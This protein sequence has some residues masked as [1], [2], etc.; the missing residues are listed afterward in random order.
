M[1]SNAHQRL[2]HYLESQGK[3]PKKAVDEAEEP[4]FEESEFDF[5][6][7]LPEEYDFSGELEEE[8]PKKMFMAR[9]GKVPSP[10]FVKALRLAR[11]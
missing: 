2:F 6:E 9:G 3:M 5:E 4:A 1:K 11:Y 10:E 8:R 7:E